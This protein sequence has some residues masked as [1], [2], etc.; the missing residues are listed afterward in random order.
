M[1]RVPLVITPGSRPVLAVH[2]LGYQTAKRREWLTAA[3]RNW[4]AWTFEQR[5]HAPSG[6][7]KGQLYRVS[8][9]AI[10]LIRL[11]Q[12]VMPEPC[13][14]A[15]QGAGGLVAVL[16]AAAAPD[17]VTGLHLVRGDGTPW[18]QPLRQTD[19]VNRPWLQ[20]VS[21]LAGQPEDGDDPILP[22]GPAEPMYEPAVRSALAVV[23]VPW[24]APE[25]HY[26]SG[27]LPASLRVAAPLLP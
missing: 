13:L 1:T 18:D 27:Y 20:A 26:L 7:A 24:W 16:A 19:L 25:G 23:R 15:G 4:G 17:L 9:F 12:D 14:L 2:D 8:D 6:W 11:L 22:F 3:A 5:G 21:S 10:D